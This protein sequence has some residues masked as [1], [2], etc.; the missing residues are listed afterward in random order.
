[1]KKLLF[2]ILNVFLAVVVLLSSTGF[3]LVEH[4]CTVKGKTTSLHKSKTFCCA[5]HSSK[6]PTKQNQTQLKKG[7][8]CSEDQRYENVEYS[9]SL[10]QITAKFVQKTIDGLKAVV[11]EFVV[12]V[13]ETIYGNSEQAKSDTQKPQQSGQDIRILNQS[14]LI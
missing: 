9:S 10:S 7:A 3:G 12:K 4:S 13:L 6:A 11:Y 5:K 1:M 8:C 2:K 14:F